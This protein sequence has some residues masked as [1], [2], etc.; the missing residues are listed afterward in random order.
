MISTL[1][2]LL[3]VLLVVSLVTDVNRHDRDRR[4]KDEDK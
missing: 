2:L 3:A 4:D 1:T